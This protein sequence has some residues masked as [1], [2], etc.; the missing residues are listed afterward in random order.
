MDH[1]VFFLA[2]FCLYLT[3]DLIEISL[4]LFFYTY[5]VL[6]W[7][8]IFNFWGRNSFK[9]KVQTWNHFLSLWTCMYA[10]RKE[11]STFFLSD[12]MPLWCESLSFPHSPSFFSL[13]FKKLSR[14][15]F[16]NRRGSYY[17]R[18]QRVQKKVTEE[19]VATRDLNWGSQKPRT[20][21]Y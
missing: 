13:L 10:L 4:F 5:I 15:R 16:E 2:N 6:I 17:G 3:E 7:L 12:I 8:F 21:C 9:R 18:Q 11:K 20:S 14:M 1:P 19:N